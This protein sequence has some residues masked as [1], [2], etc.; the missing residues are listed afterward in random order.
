MILHNVFPWDYDEYGYA[1]T[2]KHQLVL[3][4]D[5]ALHLF[6]ISSNKTVRLQ[7][8]LTCLKLVCMAPNR[9][10]SM[11]S[12]GGNSTTPPETNISSPLKID[13]SKRNF[14]FQPFICSGR[15]CYFHWTRDFQAESESL[16]GKWSTIVWDHPGGDWERSNEI[17]FLKSSWK[18]SEGN[19][20]K[21]GKKTNI[22][23]SETKLQSF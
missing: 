2:I 4:V 12:V 1:S 3:L 23:A 10:K 7:G 8:I 5:S 15:T 16:F 6:M 18:W 11:Y 17:F 9:M 14:M 20:S 19:K 21:C 22:R 13:H